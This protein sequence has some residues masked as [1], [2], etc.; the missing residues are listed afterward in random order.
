MGKIRGFRFHSLAFRYGM[1]FLIA[2]LLV[3]VVSFFYTYYY[4][5]EQLLAAAKKDAENLTQLTVARIENILQ[6]VEQIPKTLAL[7]LDVPKVEYRE[8]YRQMRDFVRDN[9]IVYGSILAFEPYAYSRNQRFYA[10]YFF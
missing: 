7:S 5:R 1:Y 3:E 6:P 9:P 8:I 10:T 4:S 2:T